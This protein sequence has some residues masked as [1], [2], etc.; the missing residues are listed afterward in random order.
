MKRLIL[1]VVIGVFLTAG[2]FLIVT[3]M[4]DR[5]SPTS[6]PQEQRV[7]VAAPSP[8]VEERQNPTTVSAPAKA[9]DE[10][11]P[12]KQELATATL[13]EQLKTYQK[14]REK[15]TSEEQ[16]QKLAELKHT[17]A[18]ESPEID[19]PE[20]R[21]DAAVSTARLLNKH[22]GKLYKF[23]GLILETTPHDIT[24]VIKNTEIVCSFADATWKNEGLKAGSYLYACGFFESYKD[25]GDF[26]QITMA[27]CYT[28]E[29]FYKLRTTP[30]TET[31][32]QQSLKDYQ[33]DALYKLQRGLGASK[34]R[35]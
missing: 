16:T 32:K 17:I 13:S 30:F 12:P 15:L 19:V 25:E 10:V 18:S 28:I 31:E 33:E 34:L 21:R 5:P 24:V 8:K 1:G 14:Q 2:A 29:N 26:K 4:M 35:Q 3:A 27:D 9:P 7:Q 6:M 11:V 20:V 23:A 22:D